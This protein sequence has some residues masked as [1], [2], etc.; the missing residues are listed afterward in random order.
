LKAK[1]KSKF[2]ESK[3][4]KQVVKKQKA[5]ARFLKATIVLYIVSANICHNRYMERSDPASKRVA[6]RSPDK[7]KID[8]LRGDSVLG[9]LFVR[10]LLFILDDKFTE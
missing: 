3:N 6:R 10:K 4:Q 7:N 9:S 1:A 8:N 2:F 5:K